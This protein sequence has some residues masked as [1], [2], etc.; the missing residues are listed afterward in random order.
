MAYVIVVMEVMSGEMPEPHP[1]QRLK[2]SGSKVKTSLNKKIHCGITLPRHLEIQQCHT[3]VVAVSLS[4]AHEGF[5]YGHTWEG[6][7]ATCR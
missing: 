2:V 1:S 5:L 3:S 6:L 4:P 7:A